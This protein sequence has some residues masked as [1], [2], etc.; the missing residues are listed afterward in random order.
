M[1]NRLAGLR[2]LAAGCVFLGIGPRPAQSADKPAAALPQQFT[3]KASLPLVSAKPVDGDD[4]HALKDPSLVYHNKR[5]HLFC[6]VRGRKRS[7]GIVYLSF[8]D[9]ESA[10]QATQTMLPLH[11]G[12]FCA[13]QVFFF[14]PQRQ[15][16]LI[17]QASD[18]T[19]S[20]EYQPAFATSKDIAD[21]RAWSKLTPLLGRKPEGIRNW[22]DFWV[23]CDE[24][25][26]YL[27]FTTLDGKMWRSRTPL[28]QFPKGWSEP[29]I[30]LQGDVFEASHTYRLKGQERYLTLIE[31]Q[32][33]HGWRYYKAYTADRL[34]GIWQ[35]LAATKDQAFA[36]MQNV[37]QAAKRWT[38]AIS[39]GELIRAGID[40][41]LEV[42]PSRLRFVFQGALDKER[43]G[44]SYG[45]IPWRL[46]ILEPT[47]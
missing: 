38:D 29:A 4:K 20:P 27:F 3:W 31:A 34:D 1:F 8:A 2:W 43:Q 19:W 21:P 5:W 7:H 26:A 39:H 16:Y 47:K 14:R 23:I 33:G 10:A 37:T 17:C 44:K 41:R 32:N 12:F 13:P 46:G 28:D 36:S 35:P 25:H 18:K 40:E 30:A 45:E 24:R 22:L 6:T 9:W 42:D 15:W 11:S